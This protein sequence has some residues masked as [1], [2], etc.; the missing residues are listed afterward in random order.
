MFNQNLKLKIEMKRFTALLIVMSLAACG[1]SSEQQLANVTTPS[2][3][4]KLVPQLPSIVVGGASGAV[5]SD[6]P[7]KLGGKCALDVVNTPQADQIIA[8]KKR[9]DFK[10]SGWAYDEKEQT[11]PEVAVFQLATADSRFHGLLAHTT[12]RPD[13]AKTFNNP[14]LAHAGYD[15]D[16]DISGVPAG[17]YEVLIILGAPDTNLVCDTYRKVTISD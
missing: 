1:K 17:T 14:N 12:L 5:V 8:V 7:Y 3:R 4:V 6:R 11:V 9:G 15:G 16:F 13:V 10:V 2:L